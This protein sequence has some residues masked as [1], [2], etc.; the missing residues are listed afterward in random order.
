MLF[1]RLWLRAWYFKYEVFHN[2]RA[3]L[4][5][6]QLLFIVE[7]HGFKFHYQMRQFSSIV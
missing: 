2:I 1:I 7:E 4:Q 6:Q 5:D 3:T